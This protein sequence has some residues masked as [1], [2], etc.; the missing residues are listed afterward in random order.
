MSEIY[1]SLTGKFQFVQNDTSI[2]LDRSNVNNISYIASCS[3]LAFH[4]AMIGISELRAIEEAFNSSNLGALRISKAINTYYVAYHAIIATML[5]YPGFEIKVPRKKLINNEINLEVSIADLNS[6]NKSPEQWNK[7]KDYEQDLATSI[8]HTEIK[9]FCE[10]MRR[11]KKDGKILDNVSEVI[12]DRF[13]QH[14]SLNNSTCIDSLYE[15][16]CYVRDRSVYRPTCV[17]DKQ[18]G[19]IQTSMYVR[20]EI[21]SLPTSSQLYK[22]LK[23]IYMAV[24]EQAKQEKRE[25]YKNKQYYL[26]LHSLWNSPIQEKEDYLNK[27][28]Y[29]KVEIERL[30]YPYSNGSLCLNSHI[31]HLIEVTDKARLFRDLN[32]FWNPLEECYKNEFLK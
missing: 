9:I 20:D 14:N 10:N 2:V 11:Y 16:L 27:L 4:K 23:E 24:M 26:F 28:G 17:V 15:K 3:S 19:F 7:Q 30:R 31:S 21:D 1:N 32:E 18:G 6:D 8:S 13:V 29:T 25:K 5:L 22:Y 12:Y